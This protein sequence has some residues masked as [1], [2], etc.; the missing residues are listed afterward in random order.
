MTPARRARLLAVLVVVVLLAG[1]LVTRLAEGPGTA[2]PVAPVTASATAAGR[3]TTASPRPARDPESGLP[4]VRA[5]DLPREARATIALIDAGGPFPYAKDGS[6][7]SNAEGLLPR[8]SRGWYREYTVPTPGESDRGARRIVTGDHDRQLFWT[9][10]H[11]ASFAR[12]R[13]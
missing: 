5:A 2:E 11:Y 13:R 4:W 6:T 1:V 3:A 10:D 8:R 9:D 7:F 12:V